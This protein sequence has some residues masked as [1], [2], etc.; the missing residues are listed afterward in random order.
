MNLAHI[1]DSHPGDR[2]ALFS[3]GRPTT[4][5]ALREQVAHVRGGLAAVGLTKGDRIV[6]LCNNGRYFVDLYLAALGLGA[7][8]VPLNPSS[9]APEIEREVHTV[10][11]KIVVV[12]PSAAHAWAQVQPANV[13]TV[14]T[15][16]ATETGSM[17]AD[18]NFDDLLAGEQMAPVEVE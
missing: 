7:V 8:V 10:G 1:I 6:L 13:P 3:R 11:A 4:Y 5:A 16:V 15:I 18:L 2:V 12:D 9:P 14:Q 17:A